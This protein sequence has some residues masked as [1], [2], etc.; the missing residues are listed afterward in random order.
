MHPVVGNWRASDIE[1]VA[2]FDIDRRKVG[3]PLEKAIFSKPN[4]TRVFQPTMPVSRTIVQM[5]PILDGIAPH[6]AEYDED[7]AFRPADA[8]PVDVA[9]TL[10]QSGAEILICYLPVGS[11]EA[12]RHY[13]NACLKAGVAL[14]NCVPVFIASDP[15]WAARFRTAGLPIIGDDVKSQL[16][17]TIVHRALVRLF[18][19]RGVKVDRTYQ[20]NTGG[21]TDFLNMLERKRLK[22]KKKSKTGSV[23]SQLDVPLEDGDIH[24]GPSDYVPWQGDNK[25][26]FI[27]IEGRGFGDVPL[28][29]ELRLSVQD[30]P[31]SAGVVI[32]AI[33]FAKLGLE[34]GLAGP[35]I[36]PS[37]YY[38]K[39]PPVQMRDTDAHDLCDAFIEEHRQDREPK[40]SAK[41][42]AAS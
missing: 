27:R 7:E 3:Q 12:V 38:M 10:K 6:M 21:N 20:L 26:C 32:D 18:N 8:E 1:V 42:R 19:D 31:N 28:D 16:G 17:A 13:A 25:I 15:E 2:A 36:A 22:S 5:G 41:S 40:A 9:A 39:S 11:E 33:R 14:V 29:L 34:S 23:Q 4:C 37:A 30:S 24:I 35:L